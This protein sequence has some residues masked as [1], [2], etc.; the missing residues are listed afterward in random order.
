MSKRGAAEGIV[1]IFVLAVALLSLYFM[2]GI[3]GKATAYNFEC[4]VECHP[5]KAVKSDF[6]VTSSVQEAQAL[7]NVYANEHC[8]PGTKYR[9]IATG[10]FVVPGAKEYG[11]AVRGVSA[12]G[13]RAFPAGRA[14]ELPTQSCYSCTTVP[15]GI[16]ASDRATAERVC[17]ENYGGSI[18]SESPGTC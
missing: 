2:M 10:N 13:T 14:F 15:Q 3:G 18:T 1:L 17:N 12:P 8:K 9:A 11:G 16:T 6:L 5:Q 7:C 4:V